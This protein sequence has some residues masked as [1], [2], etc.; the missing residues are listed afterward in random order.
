VLVLD[1]Y[2]VVESLDVHESM[3][4][5]VEHLPPPGRR[6]P[7]RAVAWGRRPDRVA[8][9]VGPGGQPWRSSVSASRQAIRSPR[10][11][12]TCS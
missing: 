2:H 11:S 12:S 9:P 10:R 4:F 1:D 8:L 7:S 3:L 5:L 6:R